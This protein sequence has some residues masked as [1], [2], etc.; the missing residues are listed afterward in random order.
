MFW[1]VVCLNVAL[2]AVTLGAGTGESPGF[3]IKVAKNV[4]RLGRRGGTEPVHHVKRAPF[5]STTYFSC[6][7]WVGRQS[8]GCILQHASD[9]ATVDEQPPTTWFERLVQPA[10]RG[11]SNGARSTTPYDG[12]A[13]L[14][15]MYRKVQPFDSSVLIDLITSHGSG[16]GRSDEDL[17]FVSWRDFDIAL[18]SDTELFRKLAELAKGE[19]DVL[20]AGHEQIEFEEFVPMES[21]ANG[22]GGMYYRVNRA[23]KDLEKEGVE[24]Q[25]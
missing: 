21:A 24:Y 7:T 6:C 15:A 5:V 20:A 22:A 9:S 3:F 17:K 1:K 23:P 2:A 13:S 10:K 25:M 14:A 18:E 8:I 4:P 16:G 19:A 11:P 12:G